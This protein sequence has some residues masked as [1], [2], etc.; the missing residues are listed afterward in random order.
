[1]DSLSD[2]GRCRYTAKNISILSFNN[3]LFHHF[4]QFCRGYYS[5]HLCGIILNLCLML[6][7]KSASMF[8]SG[9]RF[10]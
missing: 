5:E 4:V 10:V 8:N 7:F 9:N 3:N 6:L 2:P 1:M